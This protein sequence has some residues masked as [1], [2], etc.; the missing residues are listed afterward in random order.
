MAP[1]NGGLH[2][3][4]SLDYRVNG[5]GRRERALSLGWAIGRKSL[6][7]LRRGAGDVFAAVGRVVWKCGQLF[8]DVGFRVVCGWSG[9]WARTVANRRDGVAN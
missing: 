6:T 4:K 8:A 1:A 3:G 7:G 5:L 2:K 9:F